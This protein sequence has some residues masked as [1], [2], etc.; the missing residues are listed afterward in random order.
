WTPSRHSAPRSGG[1]Y[2]RCAPIFLFPARA[3]VNGTKSYTV[4]DADIQS[5]NAAV[6]A[7]KSGGGE[8][9]NKMRANGPACLPPDCRFL[10]PA[11]QSSTGPRATPSA[12]RTFSHWPP[13]PVQP[14]I[15]P[16]NTN[17]TARCTR[18]AS[19]DHLVGAQ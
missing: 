8:G 3:I 16:I 6:S 13:L 14:R 7:L 11:P 12:T 4:S 19:L 18:G 1:D 17:R 15:E 10:F 5:P 9:V 2:L